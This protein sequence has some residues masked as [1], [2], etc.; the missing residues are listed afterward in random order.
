MSHVRVQNRLQ[1][2][3]ETFDKLLN[4]MCHAGWIDLIIERAK[5]DAAL[6]FHF[7][8]LGKERFRALNQISRELWDQHT[9]V[10]PPDECSELLAIVEAW[11]S[12]VEAQPD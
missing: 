5:E 6:Q 10:M 8:P 9:E 4:R 2:P 3:D 11:I 7:T 12:D 1:K